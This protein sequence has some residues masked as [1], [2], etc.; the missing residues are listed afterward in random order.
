MAI[1]RGKIS[2]KWACGHVESTESAGWKD[3]PVCMQNRIKELEAEKSLLDALLSEVEFWYEKLHYC[4]KN[5]DSSYCRMKVIQL[6]EDRGYDHGLTPEL[7]EVSQGYYKSQKDVKALEDRIAELEDNK[8]RLDA[9][10][11]K[12]ATINNRIADRIRELKAENERLREER[13]AFATHNAE[14]E[15][16]MQYYREGVQYEQAK[17]IIENG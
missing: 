11:Q 15:A 2:I 7:W 3:C 12:S 14:L 5:I 8:R 6:C 17:A 1:Q 16:Y 9:A 13:L 4:H 10:L